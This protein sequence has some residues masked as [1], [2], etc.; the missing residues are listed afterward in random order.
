MSECQL[1]SEYRKRAIVVELKAGSEKSAWRNMASGDSL[2]IK[3]P[4][5]AQLL[6]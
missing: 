6:F 1:V 4:E 2:M 3:A 5:L